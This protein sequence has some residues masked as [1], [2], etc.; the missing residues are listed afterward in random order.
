VKKKDD[1]VSRFIEITSQIFL[2][3]NKAKKDGQILTSKKKVR[4]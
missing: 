3:K 2:P 4:F 1:L